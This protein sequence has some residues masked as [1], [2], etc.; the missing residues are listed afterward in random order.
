VKKWFVLL[1][2]LTL[3][4]S[5]VWAASSDKY[6]KATTVTIS[7]TGSYVTTSP[8]SIAATDRRDTLTVNVGIMT[9]IEGI[10]GTLTLLSSSYTKG[11]LFG[12]VDTVITKVYGRKGATRHLIDSTLTILPDT[13]TV[14]YF[15][16]DS[17]ATNGDSLILY[18]IWAD[19]AIVAAGQTATTTFTPDLTL[20]QTTSRRATGTISMGSAMRID[21]IC[22]SIHLVAATY[23]GAGTDFGDEDTV[24]TV[25][26]SMMDGRRMLIDSQAWAIPD[27]L[28]IPY[29]DTDSLFLQDWYIDFILA[30]SA[31][32]D[33][34]STATFTINPRIKIWLKP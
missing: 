15:E 14:A 18:V 19:S 27:S 9:N 16:T 25:I 34:D 20:A 31:V 6:D 24:T 11:G 26:Y 8:L 33:R 28:A 23:S 30:D 10:S 7:G 1:A 32:V 5:S 3:I 22:G 17:L 21:A 12:A 4:G 29:V 2:V 13:I